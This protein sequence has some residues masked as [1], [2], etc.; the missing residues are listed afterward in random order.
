[1]ESYIIFFGEVNTRYAIFER[2][3]FTN[4]EDTIDEGGSGDF[5]TKSQLIVAI[6][7]IFGTKI[8]FSLR[9]CSGW[10]FIPSYC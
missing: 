3:D 10:I 9:I 1:M 7:N 6:D 4:D 5:S 2:H 8:K